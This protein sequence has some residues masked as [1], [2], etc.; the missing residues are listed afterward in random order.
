MFVYLHFFTHMLTHK[1]LVTYFAYKPLVYTI[2]QEIF[3]SGNL[4]V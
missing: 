2:D 4:G 1:I 3:A